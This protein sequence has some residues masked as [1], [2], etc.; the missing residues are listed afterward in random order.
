MV[1][2]ILDEFFI[3]FSDLLIN[4][5]I[6]IIDLIILFLNKFNNKNDSDNEINFDNKKSI[7]RLL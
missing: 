2:V 3:R 5:F 1:I 6:R 4:F 7:D